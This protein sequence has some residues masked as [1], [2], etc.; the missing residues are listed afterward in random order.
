MKKHAAKKPPSINTQDDSCS[1]CL[2]SDLVSPAKMKVEPLIL[3]GFYENI[4]C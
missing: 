1:D 2:K 3:K 4:V